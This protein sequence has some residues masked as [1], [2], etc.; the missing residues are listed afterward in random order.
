[1]NQSKYLAGWKVLITSRTETIAMHG[2][3]RYVNFK[4]ECLTILES[5]ILF[6]RI[7]MPRVDE[8]GALLN[9]SIFCNI[10]VTMRWVLK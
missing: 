10:L 3:R 2:N 7:A 1:M 6:Q 9:K 5:W 8:S 4:P